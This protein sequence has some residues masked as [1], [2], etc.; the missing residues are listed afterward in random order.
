MVAS[1]LRA[2]P[3]NIAW[4]ELE[5]TESTLM[6]K[7]DNVRGI[8][9]SLRGLGVSISIDDF[10][11]GYSSLAYLKAFPIDTLKI[12]RSF[13]TDLPLDTDSTAIVRAIIALAHSLGLEVIAEGVET[14]AQLQFLSAAGCEY[15]Q[16]Y[17]I[18]KAKPANE[19][20]DPG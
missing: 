3:A 4:L 18:G 6:Q 13:V 8:L 16:G 5:L 12:D 20:S 10:G 9:D 1:A 2:G 7:H 14:E 11:T 15:V 19:I 17:L